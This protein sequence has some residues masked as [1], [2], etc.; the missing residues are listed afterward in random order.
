MDASTSKALCWEPPPAGLVV[1]GVVTGQGGNPMH[2]Y[3]GWLRE[4]IKD[5][6][7]QPK[8]PR[9]DRT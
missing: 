2:D 3:E 6:R 8:A 1:E 5:A 4:P 7:Y 9:Q